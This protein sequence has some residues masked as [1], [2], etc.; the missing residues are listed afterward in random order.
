MHTPIFSTSTLL[1]LLLIH[2]LPLCAQDAQQQDGFEEPVKELNFMESVY[3]QEKKEFQLSLFGNHFERGGLHMYNLRYEVEY[4]VTQRLQA[5]VSLLNTRARPLETA[6]DHQS[7]YL[8]EGGLLYNLIDTRRFAAVVSMVGLFPLNEKKSMPEGEEDVNVYQYTPHLVLATQLGRLQLHLDNGLEFRGA[9]R[10][11]F[12]NLGAI[13]PLGDFVPMLE[14]LCSYEDETEVFLGPG[15]AWS[16]LESFNIIAGSTFD[17]NRNS[18]QWGVN[19]AF[20]Y[21]FKAGQ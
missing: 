5:E 3:N 14:L 17:L 7:F 4:G 13:L 6:M 12:S 9:D 11:Y 16:G 1:L 20:I 8:L 19:L 18:K 10:E 15:L 2:T 21:E